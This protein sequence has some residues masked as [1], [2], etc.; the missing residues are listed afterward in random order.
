MIQHLSAECGEATPL[1][2]GFPK[3]Q[4]IRSDA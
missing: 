3:S 4:P 2:Y 1:T